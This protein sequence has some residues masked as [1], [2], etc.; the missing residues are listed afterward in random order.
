MVFILSNIGEKLCLKIIENFAKSLKDIKKVMLSIKGIK[1]ISSSLLFAYDANFE[2]P[3]IK[4][5][6]FE[7]A[8]VVSD[9]ELDNEVIEGISNLY[10]IL[11]EIAGRK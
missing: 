4:L 9:G 11:E 1:F 3:K 10:K 7:I 8:E 2:C 6:D 5:I